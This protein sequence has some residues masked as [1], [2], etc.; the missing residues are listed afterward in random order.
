MG[1]VI[2]NGRFWKTEQENS[3]SAFRIDRNCMELMGMDQNGWERLLCYQMFESAIMNYERSL[4]SKGIFPL[5][6]ECSA[7][8][9]ITP[10]TPFNSFINYLG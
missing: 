1:N 10:T 8:R 5:K 6:G 7:W 9:G 2:Q 3:A 4:A